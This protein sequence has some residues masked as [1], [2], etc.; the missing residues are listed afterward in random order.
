MTIP[1][2]K[3][4]D[5]DHTEKEIFSSYLAAPGCFPTSRASFLSASLLE[6]IHIFRRF[7]TVSI[8]FLSERI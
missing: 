4:K 3:D 6:N 2:F 8:R 7:C 1:K 5:T